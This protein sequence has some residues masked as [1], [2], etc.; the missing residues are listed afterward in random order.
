MKPD[1]MEHNQNK[2]KGEKRAEQRN[3]LRKGTAGLL[4]AGLA[5]SLSGCRDEFSV[6]TLQSDSFEVNVG[7]ELSTDIADYVR[8]SKTMMAEMTLDV[9]AVDVNRIGTYKAS[10][11]YEGE[12]KTVMISVTDL[13]APVIELASEVFYLEKYGTLKLSDV[14]TSVTDCSEYDYGFSDDM[15]LADDRKSMLGTLSYTAEGEY[16]AEVIAGDIYGNYSV[17]EFTVKVVQTGEIPEDAVQVMDY[18]AFMN[19]N[20]GT[21]LTDLNRYA[22]DSIDYGVGNGLEEG[23]NRPD[24]SYYTNAYGD[25][26]VDFIQ[27]DSRFLWLTFNEQYERGYTESILDT[28]KAREVT[29]VFFVTKNYMENNPELIKRMVDEGH[30]LGNLTADGGDVTGLSVNELT[31]EI[32]VLYNYAYENYGVSMYLFRA[33]SGVFNERCLA[34]AQS[35]GYRTVFWSFAYADW[36]TDD[37]PDVKTSLE[38]AVIRLHGGEILSLSGGSSTNAAML[39]DLIDVARSEGYEF[40]IYQKN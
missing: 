29:A 20:A 23:T 21:E 4:L 33:P 36:N 14:V 19:T 40:G 6:I 24:L 38:N 15:T 11:T 34:V 27:P 16:R 30:I 2:R 9:S 12:V 13:E 8:A 35:L 3:C 32:D 18:A 39:G 17:K 10:V 37:Q 31:S 28:L 22:V 25:Y 7:D 5:L 26:T 1:R